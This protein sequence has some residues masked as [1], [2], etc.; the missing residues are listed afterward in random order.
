MCSS[1]LVLLIVLTVLKKSLV[2]SLAKPNGK[3]LEMLIRVEAFTQKQYRYL[4]IFLRK[5]YYSTAI[6]LARLS[7]DT[8][9]ID[10][11]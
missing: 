10:D 2:T 7:N 5:G 8:S 9:T 1:L 6:F 11:W 4:K 3:A